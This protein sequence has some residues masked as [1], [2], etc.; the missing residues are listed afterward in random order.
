M[1][2]PL[3]PT[4]KQAVKQRRRGIRCE[5]DIPNEV[6]LMTSSSTR[7]GFST[8][9]LAGAFTLGACSYSTAPHVPLPCYVGTSVQLANPQQGQTGVSTSIG[10]VT[11]V[12]YGNNN[13]LYNTYGQWQLTLVDNTGLPTAGGNLR[14]VS[15]PSGPHPYPSD[16]YYASTIPQ[17]LGGRTYTVYLQQ[18]NGSCQA[19]SL[20][21]FST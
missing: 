21:S 13:A 16:F 11:I 20:N 15:Y 2:H 17:L 1:P 12:S 9:L 4:I 8:L 5:D 18:S 7:L 14:L 6:T 3:A 10:Q 19:I